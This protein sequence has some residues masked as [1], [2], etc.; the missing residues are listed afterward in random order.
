MGGGIGMHDRV[1]GDFP[2]AALHNLHKQRGRASIT[3]DTAEVSDIDDGSSDGSGHAIGSFDKLQSIGQGSAA[4]AGDG[5]GISESRGVTAFSLE[6]KERSRGGGT[7]YYANVDGDVP[8]CLQTSGGIKSAAG[9]RAGHPREDQQA[10]AGAEESSDRRYLW[11]QFHLNVRALT[12][13]EKFEELLTELESTEW[14]AITINETWRG[15]AEEIERLSGGQLWCGSGGTAGKHGV[16]VLL[17]SKWARKVLRFKAISPRLAVLDVSLDAVVHVRIIS[18]YF[19][20]SGYPDDAVEHLYRLLDVEISEAKK[21]KYKIILGADCNAEVGGFGRQCNSYGGFGNEFSNARGDWL[22]AWADRAGLVL[23]NT[24]FRKQPDKLWTHTSTNGRNRQIDYL[25]VE[26]RQRCNVKDTEV[27]SKLDMGSDHRALCMTMTICRPRRRRK[28]KGGEKRSKSLKGWQA[29]NVD[30]YELLLRAKC[31]DLG[32]IEQLAEVAGSVGDKCNLLADAVKETG[33]ACAKAEA[34]TK[35][36]GEKHEQIRVWIEERKQMRPG[37]GDERREVSKKIRRAIC[38]DMR[39][40]KREKI[41]GLL[42]NFTGLRHIADIKN[43]AKKMLIPSMT[44]KQGKVHTN[45]Q[46]IVNVFAPFYEDLFARKGTMKHDLVETMSMVPKIDAKEVKDALSCMKRGKSADQSGIIVEL[47]KDG[48]D[49]IHQVIAEIFNDILVKDMKPPDEWKQ[50]RIIVLFKKGDR[51]KAENYRPITLL[52]ILY[53]LF[54]RLLQKRIKSTLE[55]AQPP[56]Q[57]GFRSGFACV[58]HMFAVTQIVEN[59][60]STDYHCGY[61]PSTLKRPSTQ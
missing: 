55:K 26:A 24:H 15:E 1:H 13:D 32:L 34:K 52:P 50:S 19:P 20:H 11:R 37:Q 51:S 39:K 61:V 58:D 47:L 57:A 17:H 27:T 23:I 44:D 8:Y 35:E 12:T 5:E 31:Q 21:S 46:E 54:S 16:G 53:K 2:A 40:R 18:A 60:R 38:R 28:Y 14:D 49:V 3:A 59:V 10:R 22:K 33:I 43:N 9:A 48:G 30:E 45:R 29:D 42:E 4:G 41:N 36:R 56:D 7:G 25:M 6:G